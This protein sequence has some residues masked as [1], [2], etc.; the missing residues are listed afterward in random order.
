MGQRHNDFGV[1]DL[2][3][4][5][6]PW[7]D[8][9][10]ID[11]L[12]WIWCLENRCTPRT[13]VASTFTPQ[14]N[15]PIACNETQLPL[16]KTCNHSTIMHHEVDI[17]VVV[18]TSLLQM[19]HLVCK[20]QIFWQHA[21]YQALFT[22]VWLTILK[23]L[24]QRFEVL[25][26]QFK[27]KILNFNLGWIPNC[28]CVFKKKMSVDKNWNLIYSLCLF[29]PSTLTI[30]ITITSEH[31]PLA[32]N[33]QKMGGSLLFNDIIMVWRIYTCCVFPYIRASWCPTH[34]FRSKQPNSKSR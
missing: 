24:L 1:Q 11:F 14:H 30:L 20:W 28:C 6:Q 22:D 23:A 25:H 33:N 7:N 18:G 12:A 19:T 21:F 26:P 9:Q 31:T 29:W 10:F 32:T 17:I 5:L 4:D 3:M 27:R 13:M 15:S 2:V 16:C 34:T 8:M